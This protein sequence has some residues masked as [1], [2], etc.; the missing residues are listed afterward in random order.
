[1]NALNDANEWCEVM[2]PAIIINIFEQ[3]CKVFLR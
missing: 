3:T 1:M 2:S